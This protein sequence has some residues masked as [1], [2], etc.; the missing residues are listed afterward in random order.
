MSAAYISFR[1]ARS[2]K[3]WGDHLGAP[4]RLAEQPLEQIC[5]ADRPAVAERE[6]QMGDARLKVVV[7]TPRSLLTAVAHR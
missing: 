2:P 7:K 3:A 6:T 5:G 4:A 1:T